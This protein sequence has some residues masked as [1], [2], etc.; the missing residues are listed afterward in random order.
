MLT[1]P[2]VDHRERERGGCQAFVGQARVSSEAVG[3][4]EVKWLS[5]PAPL[6]ESL[7]LELSRSPLSGLPALDATQSQQLV[8]PGAGLPSSGLRQ[9]ISHRAHQGL[10]GCSVPRA[11]V[12]RVLA[13][14]L[15]T[16]SPEFPEAAFSQITHSANIS[17]APSMPPSPVL[18]I[19]P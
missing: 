17:R 13:P 14:V 16:G 6:P 19:S 1:K 9:G 5:L 8:R 10:G 4:E 12:A 11:L 7:A 2:R 15:A 3:S 18:P